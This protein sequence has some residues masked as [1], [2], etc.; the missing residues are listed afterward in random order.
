MKTLLLFFSFWRLSP[1]LV[2]INPSISIVFS[3]QIYGPTYVAV[4]FST[5]CSIFCIWCLQPEPSGIGNWGLRR[6]LCA[7]LSCGQRPPYPHFITFIFPSLCPTTISG[8]WSCKTVLKWREF[9]PLRNILQSSGMRGPLTLNPL[10]SS[11]IK[12]WLSLFQT[13]STERLYLLCILFLS[14]PYQTRSVHINS[15]GIGSISCKPSFHNP[16]KVDNHQLL[17]YYTL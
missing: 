9:C 2:G 14:I 17:L 15:D 10:L 13:V 5:S 12:P 11:H 1:W 6:A 8:R 7:A 3:F 4:E 16:S